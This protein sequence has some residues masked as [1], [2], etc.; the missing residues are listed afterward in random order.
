MIPLFAQAQA[1]AVVSTA[2]AE[3]LKAGLL[4]A[5]LLVAIV[6][7]GYF[8]R[9]G[10]IERKACADEIKDL[11]KT[12]AAKMESMH[13]EHLKTLKESLAQSMRFHEQS[14]AGLTSAANAMEAQR[15]A[16][17]ELKAGFQEFSRTLSQRGR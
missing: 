9:Q 15:E 14:S 3:I 10:T 17:S 13:D 12:H 2:T 16:L 7:A 8:Y 4:G 1:E 5:L 6:V 11:N